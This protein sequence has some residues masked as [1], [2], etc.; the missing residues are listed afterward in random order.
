MHS[1]NNPRTSRYVEYRKGG[2][3]GDLVQRSCPARGN[4]STENGNPISFFSPDGGK[5]REIPRR[6]GH[7]PRERDGG[8]RRHS[9]RREGD[10]GAVRSR[11]E[12][13]GTQFPRRLYRTE[14]KRRVSS[15]LS[16]FRAVSVSVRKETKRAQGSTSRYKITILQNAFDAVMLKDKTRLR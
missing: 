3:N 5:S 12:L 16:L 15:L 4:N 8:R 10:S 2:F 7:G 14:V 13:L 6:H 11:E 1:H 9:A